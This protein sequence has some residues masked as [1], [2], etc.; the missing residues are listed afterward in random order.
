[1]KKPIPMKN[2]KLAIAGG[3]SD[4]LRADSSSGVSGMSRPTGFNGLA[5]V[6]RGGR[7]TPA[8]LHDNTPT[9]QIKQRRRPFLDGLSR[10]GVGGVCVR[11]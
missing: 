3:A 5:I 7:S 6:L 2:T 8:P 1:M 9:P 4:R 10:A 11:D